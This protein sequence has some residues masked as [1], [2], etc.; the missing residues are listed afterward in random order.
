MSHAKKRWHEA[1]MRRLET[2]ASV[3]NKPAKRGKNGFI[4]KTTTIDG[5]WASVPGGRTYPK[6]KRAK[7]STE[8]YASPNPPRVD[9]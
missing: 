3:S 6:R 4:I 1:Q 2:L 5:R 7:E 8:K 9:S